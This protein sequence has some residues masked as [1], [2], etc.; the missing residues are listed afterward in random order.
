MLPHAVM[1]IGAAISP[2]PDLHLA[3]RFGVVGWRQIG[4]TA[5]Q[6]G[7]GPR[8]DGSTPCRSPV[9]SQLLLAREKLLLCRGDRV[10]PA[11]RQLAAGSAFEILTQPL[12]RRLDPVCPGKPGLAPFAPIARQASIRSSG[13]SNGGADQPSVC[14]R[15]RFLPRPGRRCEPS[16]CP[17]S[18]A[19][20]SRSRCDRRS[21]RADP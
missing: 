5:Q 9:G 1:D 4:R 11:V 2:G 6:L 14:G 16:G 3:L 10:A 7:N 18:S 12:G 21:S 20:Q 19:G 13:I 8:P 17:P 15:L